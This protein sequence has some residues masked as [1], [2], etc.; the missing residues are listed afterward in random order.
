MGQGEGVIKEGGSGKPSIDERLLRRPRGVLRGGGCPTFTIVQ[1]REGISRIDKGGLQEKKRKDGEVVGRGCDR[2][3]AG[4][5]TVLRYAGSTEAR[6]RY[7]SLVVAGGRGKQPAGWVPRRGWLGAS[8]IEGERFSKRL[9][10]KIRGG[11]KRG[12]FKTRSF[13]RP[14]E[15]RLLECVSRIVVSIKFKVF[16]CENK[17]G[18]GPIIRGGARPRLLGGLKKRPGEAPKDSPEKEK[19]RW[20]AWPLSRNK[21]YSPRMGPKRLQVMEKTGRRS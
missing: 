2:G 8:R 10:T 3:G 18:W 15:V 6:V 19:G 5:N 7:A 9:R 16:G 21:R 12:R 1:K 4:V 14:E 11:Y 13:G 17:K 20:R